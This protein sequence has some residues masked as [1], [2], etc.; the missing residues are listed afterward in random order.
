LSHIEAAYGDARLFSLN[1]VIKTPPIFITTDFLKRR[2]VNNI[3]NKYGQGTE[4]NPRKTIISSFLIVLSL[5]AVPVIQ[6]NADAGMLDPTFGH[7]GKVN[8]DLGGHERIVI[9]RL[10]VAAVG[11]RIADILQAGA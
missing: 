7:G 4:I 8:T 2:E 11:L 1:T 3:K 10:I 5:S 6:V 9:T